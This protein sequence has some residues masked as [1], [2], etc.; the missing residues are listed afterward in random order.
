MLVV[1]VLMKP[2]AI[3]GT[4][5]VLVINPFHYLSLYR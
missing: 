5:Y 2:T 3:V 1:F 4:F